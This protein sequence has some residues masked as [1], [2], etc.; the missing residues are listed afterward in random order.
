[1]ITEE[2]NPGLIID[3]ASPKTYE[4]GGITYT[5]A[6]NF[7]TRLLLFKVGD[8]IDIPGEQ[9]SKT[10]KNIWKSG[11]YEDVEITLTRVVDNLAFINVHVTERNRLVSFAFRGIKKSQ[12][13]DLRDRIKLAQGNIVNDNMIQ[14]CINV[15][16]KYY[17]E[18]GYYNVEVRVEVVPDAKISKGVS[19]IFHI[20]KSK[21]VKIDRIVISGTSIP[22]GKL[23]KAMKGTKERSRF[24]PMS[25]MDTAILY[26][27][28]NMDYYK[29]KDLLEHLEDYFSDRV[30]LRIMKSSKFNRDD[31]EDD[32]V[33]LIN[34]LNDYGFRDAHILFD[35]VIFAD[36]FAYI[37]ID[38]S[39]GHRYYFRNI[40]FV[41]NTKYPTKLLR[42]LLNIEKGDVY[43]QTLLMERLLQERSGND[44]ASLYMNDGYLFFNAT[45]IEVRVEGDSIDLEIRIQEGKQTKYNQITVS[46]NNK[47]SDKVILREVT[48]IPG[49]M[50]T[51]ADLIRSQQVLL[52]MGYFNQESITVIPK[53]NQADGTVDLE[54]V[55]EEAS[56]DQLELSL[57][58][59]ATGLV[60][61]AGITFNNFSFRKFFK[62]GA[63]TPIP[64][65]DG[66]KLGFRASTNATWYQYYSVSFSEPWVG[67]RRPNSLSASLSYQIQTNGYKRSADQ[68]AFIKILGVS[69]SYGQKLKWPDDYFQVS[70]TLLYQRYNVNNYGSIFIFSNGFSNN[71]SYIF[72]VARNS[73]DAP[74]YPRQGSE[75]VFSAQFT[76]PYSLFSNK[77]YSQATPQEKY[78]WLELHKWKFNIS[79]F[80]RLV[81]NLVV[82][83]RFK[84][85]FMG[86]YNKDIGIA[87]FERFYLGGDGLSNF[88]LDGRE[89]IGMRGYDDSSLTP[90]VGAAIFNKFTAELRYPITLNPSATIYLLGFVEAGN[91]WLDKRQYSPFKLYKS[92]GAG[93]RVFLPMFG[94]L[95]F[96]WGYGFDEIPGRPGVNKSHFHISI[97]SSID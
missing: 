42:E 6:L 58:F 26:M 71:I 56:S 20:D 30:K 35:T 93:I 91:S 97:N 24:E 55:V 96:D 59:G 83:V 63:W 48:T 23:T 57:G 67:G 43:N 44:I 85:G 47:T 79:W 32:K 12:E 88:A 94:L 41:G 72:T 84:S 60:L 92:A 61:S 29:S 64:S 52:Q 25:K 51:R 54:F 31:F 87:P 81:E 7:D 36:N 82:N 19:L 27:I 34:K 10:I 22:H 33:S 37:F 15:I 21:K 65:G 4:V 40:D 68:Y 62:K 78:K 17:I 50:F 39:E 69:L 74:I 53:P 8:I 77:D 38:V 70:H 1:L 2:E 80:T 73:V 66:Q 3:F 89:V 28:K 16:K 95:G 76:P 45:P 9:I 11:L 86:Y 90:S 13:T 5:G 49:Q 18:K 75:I 46:G 14:T